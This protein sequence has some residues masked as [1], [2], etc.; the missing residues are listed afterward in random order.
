MEQ[1]DHNG[2][3]SLTLVTKQY[4]LTMKKNTRDGNRYRFP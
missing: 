3:I 1:E 2:P 4:R